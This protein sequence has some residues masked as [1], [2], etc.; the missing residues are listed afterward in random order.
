MGKHTRE[1]V[2]GC[3]V[4]QRNKGLQRQPAGEQ[5]PLPVPIEA[6]EMVLMDRTTHLLMH[7]QSYDSTGPYSDRCGGRQFDK[8][9]DMPP[10]AVQSH[11]Q[12]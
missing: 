4:C 10:S 5:M 12:C 1:H 7:G 8:F 3:A 2:Q 6:R 11:R 9:E